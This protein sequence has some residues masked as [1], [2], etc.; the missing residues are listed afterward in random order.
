MLDEVY[1]LLLDNVPKGVSDIL[2]GH[3]P[4]SYYGFDF[5]QNPW[6][7]KIVG[8]SS[9]DGLLCGCFCFE[10]LTVLFFQSTLLFYFKMDC[11]V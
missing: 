9:C 5:E 3:C 7:R 2:I 11:I 1:G 6:L 10:I 8:G 4:Q